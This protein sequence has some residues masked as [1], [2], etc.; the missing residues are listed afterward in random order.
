MNSHAIHVVPAFAKNIY[1]T[2]LMCIPACTWSMLNAVQTTD[3]DDVER[4]MV[5]NIV[6]FA[7]CYWLSHFFLFVIP[8]LPPPFR[9]EITTWIPT[10]MPQKSD[11]ISRARVPQDGALAVRTSCRNLLN[12]VS[13][14]VASGCSQAKQPTQRSEREGNAVTVARHCR[15]EV[16]HDHGR[17]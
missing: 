13:E 1:S 10:S 2:C 8:H 15:T 4:N 17:I 16:F 12:T 14:P 3:I 6:L 11:S 7:A 5:S 9:G